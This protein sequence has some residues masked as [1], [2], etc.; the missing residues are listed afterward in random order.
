MICVVVRRV[1]PFRRD[2]Y[3]RLIENRIPGP[4]RQ[5][6]MY[7]VASD[8]QFFGPDRKNSAR[9]RSQSD[10]IDTP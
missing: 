8:P 5:E 4:V 9:T 10:H 1:G 3:R 6:R 2:D 7:Y